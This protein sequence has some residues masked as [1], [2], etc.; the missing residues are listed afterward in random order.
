MELD[1]A[2]RDRA[3]STLDRLI[4]L[5][6]LSPEE[7]NGNITGQVKACHTIAEIRGEL[8]H[9]HGDVTER[10]RN[11][12]FDELDFIAVHRRDPKDAEELAE[13]VR[14]RRERPQ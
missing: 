9:L 10:L 4:E 2:A 1:K 3:F 5:A 12:T 11:K 6:N 14:R 7:T 13:F 8:V